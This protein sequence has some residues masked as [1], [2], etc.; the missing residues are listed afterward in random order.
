VSGPATVGVFHCEHWDWRPTTCVVC[1]VATD[2]MIQPGDNGEY[3]YMV[4]CR[5]CAAERATNPVAP[6]R[7]F[8]DEVP[9]EAFERWYQSLASTSPPNA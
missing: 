9:R 6:I 5:A 3:Q 1:E 2:Q 8:T 4:L 7:G